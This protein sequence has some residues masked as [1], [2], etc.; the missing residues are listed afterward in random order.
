M[1]D[2]GEGDALR[3][4]HPAN[5]KTTMK[6]PMKPPHSRQGPIVMVQRTMLSC[7]WASESAQRRRYEAVCET[8]LRQYSATG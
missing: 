2:R 5:P 6:M 1:G 4:N 3:K 8:Q 7:W